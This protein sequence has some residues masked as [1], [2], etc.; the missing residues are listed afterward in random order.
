MTDKAVENARR[1]R[2]ELAERINRAQQELDECRPA[3][4][5]IDQFLADYAAFAAGDL[6][7]IGQRAAAS[8][9]TAKS[10]IRRNS[11]KEDVARQARALIEA[12]GEPIP[13]DKLYKLLV[14]GGLTIEGTDPEGV[15]NTM[16]WRT[17]D[18]AGVVH[19][20]NV[21]YWLKEKAWEPA[22]YDPELDETIDTDDEPPS[23]LDTSAA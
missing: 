13:R 9:I 15:M 17:R 8:T 20:R 23:D 5:R 7:A 3:I 19:L 10:A 6:P 1:K 16:I 22:G 14:G 21:G 2:E 12:A 18:D 4:A 11:P